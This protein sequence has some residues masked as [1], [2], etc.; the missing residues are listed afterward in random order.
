MF[1]TR[2]NKN[3][4]YKLVLQ[5]LR[6]LFVKRL[7]IFS[8]RY[9]ISLYSLILPALAQLILSKFIP[10]TALILTNAFNSFTYRKSIPE[11]SLD[12]KNYGTQILPVR[13]KNGEDASLDKWLNQYFENKAELLFKNELASVNKFVYDERM[14]NLRNFFSNY[15]AGLDLEEYKKNNLTQV[16]GV[17]YYSTLVYHSS[18]TIL[19]EMNSFLL[20]Y[21]S[22]NTKKT[23]KTLNAPITVLNDQISNLSLD[24]LQVLNCI[25]AIPFSFID[26]FDGLL[27]AFLISVCTIHVTSEKRNGSKF[28]Q[29]LS[30]THY[31]IYWTSNFLFDL[32]IFFIQFTSMVFILKIVSLTLSDSA[33]ETFIIA[34]NLNTLIHLY[35]FTLMT[36]ISC[37]LVAYLWSFLFKSDIKAFLTLFLLLGFAIYF[38]MILVFLKFF[39]AGMLALGNKENML[40]FLTDATRTLFSILF[41]NVAI[42]RAIYNLKLQNIDACYIPLNILFNSKPNFF[43]FNLNIII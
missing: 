23:I 29:L 32:L 2:L 4:N 24:S 10:S 9:V 20:A 27:I 26:F 40:G 18:A 43:F 28:L 35:V 21:Y 19:N 1:N 17:L 38:D 8:R 36:S 25:E 31:L 41:P 11:L 13:I 30:G 37:A 6:A 42:K 39:N 3:N 15:Y 7:L 34:N 22:N 33:N 5:Q 12:L 14:N 16:K